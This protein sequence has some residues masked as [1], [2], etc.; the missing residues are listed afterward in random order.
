MVVPLF[1][2]LGFLAFKIIE[3]GE[4]LIVHDRSDYL[5][6][7][8][9]IIFVIALQ[10][11]HQGRREGIPKRPYKVNRIFVFPDDIPERKVGSAY[12]VSD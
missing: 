7:F 1:L 12:Y 6:T 8:V 10:S 5:E 11:G 9:V 2:D 4:T 3:Q